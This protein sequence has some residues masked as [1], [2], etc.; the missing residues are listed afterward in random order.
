MRSLINALVATACVAVPILAWMV[1]DLND[2]LADA[3]VGVARA[4]FQQWY[5]ANCLPESADERIVGRLDHM[6]RMRCSVFVNVGYGR[7]EKLVSVAA[8]D[9]PE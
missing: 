5:A 4:E 3:R 7:V 1:V 6:G 8:V 2:R 9:I